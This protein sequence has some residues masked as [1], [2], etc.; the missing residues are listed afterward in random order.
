M[1]I[2]QITHSPLSV[3]L[4]KESVSN[5]FKHN[6]EVLT[7]LTDDGKVFDCFRWDA[8]DPY[9]SWREVSTDKFTHTVN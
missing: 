6:P 1:K 5:E 3:T 9:S 8:T 4:D 7:A 2:I